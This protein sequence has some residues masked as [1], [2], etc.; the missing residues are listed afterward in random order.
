MRSRAAVKSNIPVQPF[1][2]LF[3]GLHYLRRSFFVLAL[4]LI[5]SSSVVFAQQTS[6]PAAAGHVAEPAG[7]KITLDVSE[8][9][10]SF[11]A[12][13]NS[14]GYDQ[15]LASSDPVR[16][17]IRADVIR[18]VAASEDARF[19]RKQLCA[20]VHDHPAPDPAHNISQYVSLAFYTSEPPQFKTTI[21]E[22]DL[23]PDSQNVLGYLPVLQKFYDAAHLHELWKKYQ[24]QYQA[25]VDRFHDEVAQMI[26]STDSYLRLPI[27]LPG[28]HA[29]SL[30]IEPLVAP[31]EIN[32]RNYGVNY[33][34]LMAPDEGA[35]KLQPVRHT[36]LHYVLDPLVL[37]RFTRMQPLKPILQIVQN[38]PLDEKF[39]T[40]IALLVTESVIR[41]VEIRTEPVIRVPNEDK[42]EREK[43]IEAVRMHEVDE[44]MQEGFVLTHYFYEQFGDFEKGE[45]GFE[46]AFGPM[47]TNL[48]LTV[49]R[50]E[51]RARE[52]KFAQQ[53]A[54][55]LIR[56]TIR[57]QG[58][59]LD[60]AEE[61]L[62]AGDAKSAQEI[63]ESTISSGTGD[64]GRA[65]FILAR[66]SS[67]QGHMQ[68]A[69][70]NFQKTLQLASDPRML[71]WSH[72]YLARI[73]DIREDREDALKHYNAA[74]NTG[75]KAPDTLAAAERGLQKPYE[76]PKNK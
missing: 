44:A 59:T 70:E 71:A 47:L 21:R 53:G 10:F 48:S 38:A 8:T 12:G 30:F 31:G 11:F 74:L 24:P 43:R 14:C 58:D 7:S 17:Q 34:M 32:S 60:A 66:A 1:R 75:D 61:S 2:R 28:A 27:S 20:F 64:Q 49:G 57:P 73:F 26:L 68:D 4:L 76:P 36:Y 3:L 5:S 72:I 37:K 41:A 45:V 18:A 16:D 52:V 42:K 9:F 19:Q 40:D 56:A 62:A 69:I 67:M 50:E 65:A 13:L 46:Q 51:K 23:P 55:D 33:M 22:S 25:Y 63:A 54:P 39:K 15:E 6:A 29:F 35:L